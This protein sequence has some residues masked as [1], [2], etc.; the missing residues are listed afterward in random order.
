MHRRSSTS[1][2]SFL[3]SP[4]WPRSKS[5]TNWRRALDDLE[6]SYREANSPFHRTDPFSKTLYVL[7]VSTTAIFNSSLYV[8]IGLF[9]LTFGC[10][11]FFSGVSLRAYWKLGKV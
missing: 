6:L 5:S 8:G 2:E 1:P 3:E 4:P 10:A 11:A 9:V 7:A